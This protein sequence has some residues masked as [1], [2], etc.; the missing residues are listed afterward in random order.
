MDWWTCFHH[1]QQN[2][3]YS[4]SI[5]P[6]NND[7]LWGYTTNENVSSSTAICDGKVYVCSF[8]DGTVYCLDANNGSM[9]WNYTAG[10]Y[11]LTSPAISYNKVYIVCYDEKIYC[12]D[13]VVM[14][15][16]N[17]TFLL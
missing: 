4:T 16:N 7:V 1:D 14:A 5:A 8:D 2:T 17:R 9:I 13:A 6:E 12:L 10:D 11:V 15:R 3:G